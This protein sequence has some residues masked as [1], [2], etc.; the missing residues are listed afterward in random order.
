M[1]GTATF[2]LRKSTSPDQHRSSPW[3]YIY[4]DDSVSDHGEGEDDDEFLTGWQWE[5]Q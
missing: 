1:D 4:H 3:M 5:S 2:T